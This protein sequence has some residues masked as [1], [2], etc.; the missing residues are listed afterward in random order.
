MDNLYRVYIRAWSDYKEEKFMDML[1]DF[2]DRFLDD[3]AGE[4]WSNIK[5]FH[6]NY[7]MK[8][9]DYFGVKEDYAIK[10]I[11]TQRIVWKGDYPTP[12]I[13]RKIAEEGDE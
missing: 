11:Y 2:M 9:G 4:D 12:D 3:V 7:S 6:E 10:N 13:I 8:N 1:G 5:F